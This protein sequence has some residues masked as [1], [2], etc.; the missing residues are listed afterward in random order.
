MASDSVSQALQH[1]VHVERPLQDVDGVHVLA[2]KALTSLAQCGVC[3]GG[4]ARRSE[5]VDRHLVWYRLRTQIAARPP[6]EPQ[7]RPV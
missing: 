1:V 5:Q 7:E 2:R 4:R 6:E 3:D